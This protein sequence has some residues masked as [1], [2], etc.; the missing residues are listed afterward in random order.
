VLIEHRY[1]G[2]QRAGRKGFEGGQF[3]FQ[4]FQFRRE[5]NPVMQSRYVVISDKDAVPTYIKRNYEGDAETEEFD[6]KVATIFE[7]LDVP[8]IEWEQGMPEKEDIVPYVDYSPAPTMDDANWELLAGRDDTRTSPFL[9]EALARVITP[10]MGDSAKLHAIYDFVNTEITGEFGMGGS[11]A[12][13]LLEK[14]GDRG[15]LFESMA[16]E[17]GIPYTLGRAMAWN[18]HAHDLTRPTASMFGASFLY[19]QPSDGDAIPFFMGARHTPFGLIPTP[20]RGSFA[21]L[22][23]ERG[24]RIISLPK[25]GSRMDNGTIFDVT[26]GADSEATAIQGD[27]VYR[28][29]G[30]YRFKRQL[31]E[32]PQHERRKFAEGQLSGYFASPTLSDFAFPGVKTR[33]EPLTIHLKG[34]MPQYLSRQG[35]RFVAGVGLPDSDMTGNYVHRP[36][37][38]YDLILNVRNDGVDEYTIELGDAFE[39]ASLPAD[40][41]ALS[42]LGVYSL[43]YR[44]DGTTLHVRRERHLQPARLSPEQYGDFIAWCK[45]IDDA[46]KAK[47]EFR[48]R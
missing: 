4:D 32:M 20:Y 45:A 30:G 21:F 48:A 18:G 14:A 22:C 33:G 11:P 44:L 7:R 12:A 15:Q 43:T 19:L 27:V 2:H 42:E 1:L 16:R 40:H 41:L 36:E 8:R 47:I 31:E 46:E 3:F 5:P 37:R 34:T 6:G 29:G 26:L 28:S 24:G 17:A 23:S 13:I 9:R 39:I 10:E 35:D 25:G 38:V